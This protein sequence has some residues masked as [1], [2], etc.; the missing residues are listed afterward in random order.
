MYTFW[1]VQLIILRRRLRLL[2]Q[3]YI[4]RYTYLPHPKASLLLKFILVFL[5]F[6]FL[7]WS[8]L[9]PDFGWHLQAGNYIRQY[10]IPSHDI[11]TYT[12]NNFRWIDHEWGNDV[13]VSLLYSL[14]GYGLLAALFA[15][16]WTLALFI[17][18][19][20]GR[21]LVLLLAVIALL[22]Y[23]G[24]RPIAWTVCLLAILL[25]MLTNDSKRIYP[26][27][28][29][30]FIVWA[31][32]HAGFIVGLAVL[33]YFAIKTRKKKLALLFLLCVLA[34]FVNVYG[35]RLYEEI[36]RT[37][38]DRSLHNQITEWFIFSIPRESIAFVCLWGAGFWIFER[39]KLKNWLGLGPI[40]FLASMSASRNVPL[41]V[42]TSY[43]DLD[44]YYQNFKGE[45]PDKLKRAKKMTLRLL[46]VAMIIWITFVI[47]N[48]FWPWRQREAPYP[49][50]AVAYLQ[51]HPCTGHIFNSYDYGGYLIWKL[52]GQKVY[53]DGRMPSW[54][55]E[56]GQ[57][58]MNR[59]LQIVSGD[60]YQQE[61]TRYNIQCVLLSGNITDSKLL[62]N[63]K[64]SGWYVAV[65]STNS[66]LMTKQRPEGQ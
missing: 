7:G 52:P 27:I 48:T 25:R 6:F 47:Y 60:S 46:A 29:I 34:T 43:R 32:L 21:F 44:T 35:P 36:F 17:N 24:I 30:L 26:F 61:F 33:A 42:V 65:Q 51:A 11:F 62:T 1:I 23:A 15:G 5:I 57:K 39:K 20:K 58:Y 64:S 53:I 14:G 54:R 8:R 66:I 59:Y 16:L 41:F 13:I 50:Q 12:A 28:P 63:L 3:N 31:N 49:T 38:F 22:P 19:L 2:K 45:I 37:L 55:D 56:T 9:D 10:G 18:G 40:M 4:R